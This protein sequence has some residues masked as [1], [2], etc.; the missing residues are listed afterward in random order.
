[1]VST[2]IHQCLLRAALLSLFMS[3]LISQVH[4]GQIEGKL[5]VPD[6]QSHIAL[7][8]LNSTL[9]TLND[10][11]F[12]T[13]SIPP[14]NSFVF[15][16]VPPGVHVLDV[17]ST[18]YHFSQ[19][20]IQILDEE[21]ADKDTDATTPP[22][23]PSP[24]CI[25]YFYPGATKKPIP[26]PLVL[27]ANAEYQYYQPRPTFSPFSILRSPMILIMIFSVGM[28]FVMPKMMGELDPD[29]KQQMKKQMEAQQD[30]TKMLSQLWGEISGAG[31]TKEI[32]EKKVV[33][34]ER[35]KRE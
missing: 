23:S 14:T 35:L 13:Y 6:P 19:I 10:G 20:K 34:K 12:S 11:E 21:D 26:H 9:L 24:K 22:T 16:N 32:T 27:Y 7:P 33:R 2:R 3:L 8:P 15:H 17:H 31:E 5:E 30:P 28:M 1:M 4:G 18:H 29:Q 25:E